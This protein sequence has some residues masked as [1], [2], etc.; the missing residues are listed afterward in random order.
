MEQ[1]KTVPLFEQ[2]T[3]QIAMDEYGKFWHELTDS[4][5]AHLVKPVAIR[6]AELVNN[7]NK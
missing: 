6:Y 4:Q 1:K 2:A 7:K 3:E 5:K